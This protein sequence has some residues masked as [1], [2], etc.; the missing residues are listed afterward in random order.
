MTDLRRL[1][2]AQAELT[3]RILAALQEEQIPTPDMVLA[4][5]NWVHIKSIGRFKS[6]IGIIQKFT[7]KRVIILLPFGQTTNRAP[8]NLKK[9]D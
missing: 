5:G 9:A 4:I 1:Q 3:D 2:V 7:K 8:H 6:T